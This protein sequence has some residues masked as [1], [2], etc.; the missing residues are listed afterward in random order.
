M[1]KCV[2]CK[3]EKTIESFNKNKSKKD[4]YNNICR[5]CSKVR[6]KQYYVDNTEEH[7]KNIYARHLVN[8][9]SNRQKLKEYKQQHGCPYCPETEPVCLDLHHLDGDTKERCVSETIHRGWS[10]AKIQKELDKCICI[11]SNCH[12]KLHAGLLEGVAQLVE[13]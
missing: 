8:V 10:W 9:K 11:C 4:G 6:S 13:H 2:I 1:K 12:R 3:I 7:K 5:E